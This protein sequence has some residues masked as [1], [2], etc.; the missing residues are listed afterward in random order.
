MRR[1]RP[2]CKWRVFS[3]SWMRPKRLPHHF[4]EQHE[5]AVSEAE[6]RRRISPLQSAN[7]QGNIPAMERI[8][9]RERPPWRSV[10]GT[11]FEPGGTGQ[12]PGNPSAPYL[13]RL[14]RSSA[15]RTGL[16]PVPCRIRA[17]KSH[18]A[19]NHVKKAAASRRTPKARFTPENGRAKK[20]P[21]GLPIRAGKVA[22]PRRGC[23]PS[24][25]R[26]LGSTAQGSCPNHGTRPKISSRPGRATAKD[27]ELPRGAFRRRS[28]P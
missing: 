12:S 13:P 21:T 9:C 24:R 8:R 14:R 10:P 15:R 16:Q 23:S 17:R 6:I 26:R 19:L 5:A 1:D 7:Q 4:W 11:R 3:F 2:R 27:N 20:F 28:V 25:P 22:L 18:R